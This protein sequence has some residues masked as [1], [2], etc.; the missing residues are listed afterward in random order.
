M[1][2][3][4]ERALFTP[5]RPGS[6]DAAAQAK[7]ST[8][9]TLH[10]QRQRHRLPRESN[11]EAGQQQDV[12]EVVMAQLNISAATDGVARAWV[13]RV[14]MRPGERAS[15]ATIDGVEVP[16]R[17]LA[18]SHLQPLRHLPGEADNNT[19]DTEDEDVGKQQEESDGEQHAGFFPFG[20]RGTQPPMFAG[21]VVELRLAQAAHAR[22]VRVSL[23][24]SA[25]HV[26]L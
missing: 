3:V 16:A 23:T 9:L 18:A 6:A 24:S 25:A 7:A 21:A 13:V 22:T 10:Q 8:F 26:R 20:G 4:T 1:T 14:H 5:A 11:G 19:D 15:A 2:R 17:M 12:Q